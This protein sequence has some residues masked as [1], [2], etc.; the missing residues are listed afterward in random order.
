M[1]ATEIAIWNNVGRC[2]EFSQD[3]YV[4]PR[5]CIRKSG[6]ANSMYNSGRT[7]TYI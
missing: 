2:Q 3:R 6:V 7:F 5:C 1:L 4:E